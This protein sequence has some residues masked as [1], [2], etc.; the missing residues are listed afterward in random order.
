VSRKSGKVD[1]PG[2]LLRRARVQAGLSQRD[3]AERLGVSHVAVSHA[4]AGADIRHDTLRAY[5]RSL[6]ALTPTDL[7]PGGS[8]RSDMSDPTAIWHYYRD[9]VGHECRETTD[10]MEVHPDGTRTRTQVHEGLRS[11][12]DEPG[13]MKLLFGLDRVIY[14]GV[15]ELRGVRAHS[16]RD[17]EGNL[18]RVRTERSG[19]KARHTVFIPADL[20]QEGLNLERVTKLG[21]AS[22]TRKQVFLAR[23]AQDHGNELQAGMAHAPNWPTRKLTMRVRFPAEFF[24]RAAEVHVWPHGVVPDPEMVNSA[25]GVHPGLKLRRSKARLELSFVVDRPL[26]GFIYSIGWLLPAG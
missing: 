11:V 10:L 13:P 5:F 4:E 16:R 26:M 24:P 18:V 7:L 17:P 15:P 22:M 20:T 1:E 8:G 14:S 23:G 9:L 21:F 2:D 3:L 19:R 6:P 25:D 12:R